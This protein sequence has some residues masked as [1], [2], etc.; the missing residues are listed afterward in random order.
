MNESTLLA[1]RLFLRSIIDTTAFYTRGRLYCTVETARRHFIP[2]PETHCLPRTA[3]ATGTGN[4]RSRRSRDARLAVVQQEQ[5]WEGRLVVEEKL[6]Y[7]IREPEG[8]ELMQPIR[9]ELQR[10]AAPQPTILFAV[11]I[12]I[13]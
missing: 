4:R 12:E 1:N 13:E 7:A 11:A 2:A 6:A 9:R 8:R 3:C 5:V 10:P